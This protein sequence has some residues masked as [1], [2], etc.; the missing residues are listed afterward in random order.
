M[1]FTKFLQTPGGTIIVRT[2]RSYL[3]GLVGF[4]VAGVS[5]VAV[6]AAPDFF[7]TL[8]NAASLALAPAVV[9]LLQNTIELLAK[10]DESKPAL[11]G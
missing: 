2:V 11:R 7:L 9:A 8:Q 3:Q 10:I 5:G 1:N 4:L 6:I